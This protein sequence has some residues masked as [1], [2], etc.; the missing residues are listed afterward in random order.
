MS[1]VTSV[2]IM[3]CGHYWKATDAVVCGAVEIGQDSSLWFG[4]VL[5][6][7]V[8][9]I[10]VGRRVNVQEHAVLHCDS[11]EPLTI[12]DAVTIGHGAVVHCA[13]VGS[14]SLIGIKAVLLG[15]A[16]IGRDCLIA[17]GAVV[18]P[19]TVVP[20]GHVV[21]GVPGKVVRALKDSERAYLRE[22]NDHYVELARRHVEEVAALYGG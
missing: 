10:T 16:V 2:R 13:A 8:A 15:R 18:A 20:D 9:P 5:R 6:G 11:G 1:E 19:G 3:R 4:A 14:G 7:D 22:N 12:G 21:M 17:A